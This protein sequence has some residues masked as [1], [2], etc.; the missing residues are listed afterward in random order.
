MTVL[1]PDCVCCGVLLHPAQDVNLLLAGLDQCIGSELIEKDLHSR[2]NHCASLWASDTD[3]LSKVLGVK[4]Y[5]PLT[6]LVRLEIEGMLLLLR[7]ARREAIAKRGAA[8]YLALLSVQPAAFPVLLKL[9]A[10]RIPARDS[11]DCVEAPRGD[12]GSAAGFHECVRKRA[13]HCSNSASAMKI[14]HILCSQF[15]RTLVG[16]VREALRNEMRLN[17]LGHLF[18]QA[19]HACLGQASHLECINIFYNTINHKA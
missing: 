13:C 7:S 8:H 15:I 2:K 6:C 5:Q 16:M 18:G 10:A 17:L 1:H 3:G 4:M 9:L 19:G 14:R 11:E 12:C